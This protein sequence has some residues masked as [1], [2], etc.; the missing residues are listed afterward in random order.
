MTVHAIEG[1]RT[2]V[3]NRRVEMDDREG[4]EFLMS[5]P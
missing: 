4:I 2:A 5:V 3:E 1:F